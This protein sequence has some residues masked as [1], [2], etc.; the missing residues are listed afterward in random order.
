MPGIS[1]FELL[2]YIRSKPE[3]KNIPVI[4]VT[5]FANKEII[6]KAVNAGALDYIIKPIQPGILINKIANIF[7]SRKKEVKKD[8]PRNINTEG[9]KPILSK[10]ATQAEITD[11]FSYM[12]KALNTACLLGN[13]EVVEQLVKELGIGNFEDI[14]NK[15]VDELAALMV[16]FDYQPMLKIISSAFNVLGK[17]EL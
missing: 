4:F 15:K 3:R 13:C 10:N 2:D 17:F 6:T 14:I 8:G 16:S 5:G 7:D 12:F 9:Q 1:G 11:Y